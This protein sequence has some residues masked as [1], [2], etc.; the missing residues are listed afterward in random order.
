[1]KGNKKF[2]RFLM[3]EIDK[4]SIELGLLF[5]SM[6]IQKYVRK[7]VAEAKS[8]LFCESEA[9]IYSNYAYVV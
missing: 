8:T 2:K 9:L 6:N 5:I 3:K 4:V 7:K 1:M